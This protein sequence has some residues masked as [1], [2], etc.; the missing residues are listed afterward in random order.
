M[1]FTVQKAKKSN[2]KAVIAGEGLRTEKHHG[3]K[4]EG[5]ECVEKYVG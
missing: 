4:E 3:G 5:R 1:K 2:D